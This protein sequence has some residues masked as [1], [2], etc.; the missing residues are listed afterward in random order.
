MRRINWTAVFGI[1]AVIGATACIIAG[2]VITWQ[3][4]GSL[5][6]LKNSWW[7]LIHEGERIAAIKVLVLDV[8]GAIL[9]IFGRVAIQIA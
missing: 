5:A 4:I 9:Y 7:I 2:I 3:Q 1:L 8:V 6:M